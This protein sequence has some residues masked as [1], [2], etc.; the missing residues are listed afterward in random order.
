MQVV[1]EFIAWLCRHYNEVFRAAVRPIF[2]AFPFI[3]RCADAVYWEGESRWDD[4][5]F[6][7]YIYARG[8]SKQTYSVVN[9]EMAGYDFRVTSG[10]EYIFAEFCKNIPTYYIIGK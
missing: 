10:F 6:H 9:V 8:C 2:R 4:G 1:G 5:Y 7:L 3:T